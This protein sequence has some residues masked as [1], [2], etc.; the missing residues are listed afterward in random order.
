[1]VTS[2][3]KWSQIIERLVKTLCFEKSLVFLKPKSSEG[4][5]SSD[6]MRAFEI[7]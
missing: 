7:N 3:V 6:E 2:K 5:K 4:L 1:M